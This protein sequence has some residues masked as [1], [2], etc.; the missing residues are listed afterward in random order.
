VTLDFNIQGKVMI[1]M[2]NYIKNRVEAFSDEVNVSRCHWNENLF[3]VDD[4]V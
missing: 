1:D 2:V 4:E 3:K